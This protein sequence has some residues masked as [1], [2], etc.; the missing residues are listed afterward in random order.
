MLL[1][2]EN[3]LIEFRVA[4]RCASA[5]R[6]SAIVGTAAVS[7]I[8]KAVVVKIERNWHERLL[9]LLLGLLEL[10]LLLLFLCVDSEQLLMQVVDVGKFE[11]LTRFY[12]LLA[13][14][15]GLAFLTSVMIE[16]A[17]VHLVAPT[18]ITLNPLVFVRMVEPLN[19]SMTLITLDTALTVVP[20]KT[21]LESLAVLRRIFE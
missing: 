16:R 6:T 9:L 18:T 21:V 19:C 17:N 15:M 3:K 10:D 12:V 13:E 20:T 11:S 8:T 4:L 5:R 7:D 2:L 1:S 14:F